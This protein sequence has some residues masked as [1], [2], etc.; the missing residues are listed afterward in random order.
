MEASC[1]Q[2][3]CAR[4][5]FFKYSVATSSLYSLTALKATYAHFR[6]ILSTGNL[7][8]RLGIVD[9]SDIKPI[10]Y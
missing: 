10:V 8:Q 4:R 3:N 9:S 7:V 5:H 2:L 6:T 1:D